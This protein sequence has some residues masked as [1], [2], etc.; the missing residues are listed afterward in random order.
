MFSR[1]EALK[2]CGV[3]W[4]ELNQQQNEF[5]LEIPTRK[6]AIETDV[7]MQHC[8]HKAEVDIF[9]SEINRDVEEFRIEFNELRTEMHTVKV[10][11]A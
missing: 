2:K 8:E 7:D 11:C 1:L 4:T 10:K 3:V 9:H 5:A 6:R